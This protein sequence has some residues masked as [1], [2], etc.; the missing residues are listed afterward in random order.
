MFSLNLLPWR[1]E[2][3]HYANKKF[4]LQIIVSMLAGI[5]VFLIWRGLL[6]YEIQH[7]KAQ[8]KIA[9][10]TFIQLQPQIIA[11]TQLKKYQLTLAAALKI[12]QE[13]TIK[14]V[15]FGQLL[16]DLSR[17]TP[18]VIFTQLQKNNDQIVLHGKSKTVSAIIQLQQDLA[19]LAYLSPPQLLTNA[20]EN[21]DHNFVIT[22][23][24]K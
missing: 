8:Q 9:Q 19:K 11:I 6:F 17:L 21:N 23:Q 13:I 7:L 10:Q 20:L 15:K 3:Q 24:L 18:T 16:N 1:E 12:D 22:L 14:Q 5:S 2:K 4:K